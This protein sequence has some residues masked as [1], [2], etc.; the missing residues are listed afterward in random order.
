MPSLPT[1]TSCAAVAAMRTLN[2][3]LGL[4]LALLL[5]SCQNAPAR[6]RVTDAEA[7]RQIRALT[8]ELCAIVSGGKGEP[9]DWDRF[10]QLFLPDARLTVARPV[11]DGSTRL[12]SFT[13]QQFVAMA[14]RSSQQQGFHELPMVTQ[15]LQFGAVAV[16][17][18]S[19]VARTEPAGEAIFSGVNAY[20]L[21]ATDSG[22]RIAS[23]AWADEHDDLR[24]PAD[25]IDK[26]R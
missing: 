12:R 6:T 16:A 21:V 7:E 4:L 1:A 25:W 20:L 23:L 14:S 9:R 8:D 15:V 18:S 24:L 3:W 26:N 22:W 11:A 5:S 19:Y 13:P 2:P 17:F 10:E